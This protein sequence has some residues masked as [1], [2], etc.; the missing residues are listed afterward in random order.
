[1]KMEK[2][3]FIETTTSP[4]TS[5]FVLLSYLSLSASIHFLQIPSQPFASY[6]S[7]ERKQFIFSRTERGKQETFLQTAPR[8]L[9]FIEWYR[10]IDKMLFCASHCFI[11][12][13]KDKKKLFVLSFSSSSPTK[14]SVGDDESEFL[15]PKNAFPLK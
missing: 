6:P 1:M 13:E 15:T 10:K 11:E 14:A 5:L 8:K 3:N 9:C 4:K 2:S 7:V 12:G